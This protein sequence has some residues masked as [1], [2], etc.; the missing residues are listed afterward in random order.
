VFRYALLA[1]AY[2]AARA[3][4]L[5]VTDDAALLETLGHPVYVYEGAASNL[6]ITTRE[7][8]IL[9]EALLAAAPPG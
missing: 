1:A 7:D 6:K 8:L 4:H 3:Q 5:S 9:A 2:Q